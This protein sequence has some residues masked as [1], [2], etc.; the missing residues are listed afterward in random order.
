M[1]NVIEHEVPNLRFGNTYVKYTLLFTYDYCKI[2][3][4]LISFDKIYSYNF[5]NR[6]SST[7]CIFTDDNSS[8]CVILVRPGGTD[9]PGY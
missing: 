4:N 7:K 9:S 1:S 6:Q 5:D 3:S 8:T 2:S